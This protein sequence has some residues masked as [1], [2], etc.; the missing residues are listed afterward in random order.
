M[1]GFMA[2]LLGIVVGVL[3]YWFFTAGQRRG[4]VREA[5]EQIA[6]GADKIKED[7]KEVVGNISLDPN[8]IKEELARTGRVV[9]QK[10][11]KAGQAVADATENARITASIKGKLTIDPD[12]S[13]L[14]I[15]VDTTDG[16]VTLSG[17]VSSHELIAKAIKLAWETEGVRE[18]ISTLQVKPRSA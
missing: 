10:A 5:Q 1:K 11:R 7:V 4:D 13:A 15:S 8:E 14:S 12:L 18:V 16:V 2:F 9:R 17:T 3:G 6:R